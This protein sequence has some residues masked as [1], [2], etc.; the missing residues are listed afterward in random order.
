MDRDYRTSV[1][2]FEQ[3]QN[4][5]GSDRGPDYEGSERF[6]GSTY[7][8][9]GVQFERRDFN[10]KNHFGKGPKGYRRSDERIKEE[11][12]EALWHDQQVD[13][14]EIEVKVENATVTLEGKVETRQTK[15]MA[16]E[17]IADI[18]GIEDIRNQ[19][20]VDRSALNGRH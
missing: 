4:P 5:Y 17:V 20:T 1:S 7:S 18:P 14:S 2:D 15:R 19:I 13:A 11:V 16:E 6:V 12:C 3:S 9:G 10:G 8:I